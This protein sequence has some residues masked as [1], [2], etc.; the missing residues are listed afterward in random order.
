LMAPPM[1]FF[2]TIPAQLLNLGRESIG[3]TSNY[4]Y[5]AVFIPFC[6]TFELCR[7]RRS[8]SDVGGRQE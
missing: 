5:F 1:P 6:P 2:A 7:C 3:G 8:A 4:P